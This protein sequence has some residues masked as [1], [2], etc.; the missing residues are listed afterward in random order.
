MNSLRKYDV[1]C[2]GAAAWDT[3]LTGI[4][5]DLFDTDSVLAEGYFASSGGDALNTAVNLARLGMSS[6]LCAYCGE[7]AAG[8]LILQDLHQPGV[9]TDYVLRSHSVHTASPVLLV[10]ENGDR[11]IIRMPDSGNHSLR[12]DMITDDMLENARHLHVGSA[13]I[14][15]ALDGEGLGKLMKRA[16]AFGLTTSMDASYDRSGKWLDNIASALENC[17]VF[18]PSLQEASQY[19]G[20]E[21]TEVICEFFRQ[22]PLKV[23]GIKLAD[24]GVLITDFKNTYTMG[25]LFR[26][27]PADTTGAG[28]A[29]M[30]GFLCGWLKQY[31]L[32]S[33][34]ALGSAQSASVLRGTGANHT[35]GTFAEA[36]E[37]LAENGIVLRSPATA[38]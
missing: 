17:D 22:Y 32:P 23:F 31:D 34:M 36:E 5:R 15:H 11:H 30:A 4:S 9:H 26:G 25:T 10:D 1:L 19:C 27:R 38:V 12:E 7:D 24:K 13:N 28:D 14:L 16:H 21:D 33:C 35:A 2:A 20:S 3:L 37:L 29:F 18:I 6:A 8:E